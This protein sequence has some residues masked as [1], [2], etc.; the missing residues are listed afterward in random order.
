LSNR[1]RCNDFYRWSAITSGALTK[2]SWA[3][4][5]RHFAYAAGWK[6]FETMW[7]LILR[8][9]RVAAARPILERVPSEFVR[10]KPFGQR[11]TPLR[12]PH[13]KQMA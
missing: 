5:L 8:A 11:K 9:K 12:L 10:R 7:D 3:G 6:K 2:D 4:R 1:R 13:K